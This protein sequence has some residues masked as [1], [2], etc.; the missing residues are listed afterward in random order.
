MSSSSRR[1]IR[2][3]VIVAPPSISDGFVREVFGDD[4][5]NVIAEAHTVIRAS[6]FRINLG[7]VG[8]VE[9]GQAGAMIRDPS[10]SGLI[11]FRNGTYASINWSS[12]IE[13][14]GW[15]GSKYFER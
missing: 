14:Y 13:K 7:R 9:T 11:R 15:S 10:N 1:G 12:G 5:G 6:V 8:Q 3:G 4:R 2:A